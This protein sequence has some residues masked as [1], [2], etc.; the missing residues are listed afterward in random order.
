MDSLVGRTPFNRFRTLTAFTY[1]EFHSGLLDELFFMDLHSHAGGR[2]D[3]DH[4]PGVPI[5]SQN[6]AGM[7]NG[8]ALE[9]NRQLHPKIDEPSMGHVTAGY[10]V[11]VKKDEIAIIQLFDISL[12][13][14][15]SRIFFHNVNPLWE[16]IS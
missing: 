12:A 9:I 8:Q 11:I 16:S 4:S 2:T 14:G 15:V 1:N 7:E 6:R 3:G 13:I 10:K 5:L